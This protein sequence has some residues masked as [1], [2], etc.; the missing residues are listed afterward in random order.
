MYSA[1]TVRNKLSA[2]Y[3]K[4]QIPKSE[5]RVFP[6]ESLAEASTRVNV[7]ERINQPNLKISNDYPAFVQYTEAKSK[8]Y[9]YQRY[10]TKVDGD[11]HDRVPS[12]FRTVDRLKLIQSLIEDQYDLVALQELGLVHSYF[13]LHSASKYDVI[14]L[15]DLYEQWITFWR[16][17]YLKGELKLNWCI[18][19]YLRRIYPFRQPITSIKDYFGEKIALYFRWIGFYAQML[20]FPAL[21][22]GRLCVGCYSMSEYID[23][24]I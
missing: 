2:L 24:Y 19:T 6:F 15:N 3:A 17:Y 5:Y 18:L 14:N 12:I 4:D 20:M 13:A 9:L 21:C 23:E 8:Q 22:A 11:T 1:E 10:R 7:H 16:P